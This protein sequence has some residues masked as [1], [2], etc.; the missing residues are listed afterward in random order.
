MDIIG[1]I[2]ELGPWAW[3]VGGLLLLAAE[4]IVS[5]IYLFWFGLAG[6]AVGA[7]ALATPMP[8]QAQVVLFGV[9]AI[10]AVVGGRFAGR[11]LRREPAEA[12]L[13]KR[14]ESFVGRTLRLTDPIVRGEGRTAHADTF[15]RVTGPD[16]PAGS[17]VRVVEVRGSTL[18]VEP[19]AAAS[20][21]VPQPAG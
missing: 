4:I 21:A 15:W 13:N 7:I 11:R 10:V 9:L 14:G 6:V 19:V 1:F 3:I 17:E 5:G 16:L 20:Q 12:F 18:I 8:W 2:R